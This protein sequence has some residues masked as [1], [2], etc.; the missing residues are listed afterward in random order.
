MLEPFVGN[1]ILESKLKLSILQVFT[2]YDSP[3]G[4]ETL[5][6]NGHSVTLTIEPAQDMEFPM[7]SAKNHC[8]AHVL[9]GALKGF[10][11]FP[12]SPQ[13]CKYVL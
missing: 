5:T 10:Q 11:N 8:Y 12:N 1:N 6:N 7:V 2:D 9:S 13:S 4:V 3:P